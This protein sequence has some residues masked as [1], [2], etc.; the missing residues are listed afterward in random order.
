[1]AG[2]LPRKQASST[3]NGREP[4][5]SESQAREIA[6][7]A[8]LNSQVNWI[9]SDD[10]VHEFMAK[11]LSEYKDKLDPETYAKLADEVKGNEPEPIDEDIPF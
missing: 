5:F 7:A 9:L 3:R 1:M 10:D 6:D 4:N 2:V 11:F 8:L